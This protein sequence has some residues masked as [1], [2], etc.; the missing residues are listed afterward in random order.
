[1]VA[2]WVPLTV[3]ATLWWTVPLLLLS[4]YSPP[5]LDY[6]ENA[7]ITTST[8]SLPE[9]LLGTSDWGAYASRY[10]WVAGH[11]LG[12]TP[13][14][15]VDAAAVA[16][17]GVGG[18]ARRDNPH[19]RFLLLTLVLG[20][21]IVTFG[22][23]GPVHGWFAD[24]RQG[25]LDGALAPFR[26]LHKF[27]VV[28]RLPLVLGLAHLVGVVQVTA[29][30]VG[31]RALRA[32][33]LLAAVSAVAGVAIPVYAGQLAPTAPVQDVPR[34]WYAAADYL[35]AHTSAGTALELPAAPFGDYLWGSPHDDIL[36]ALAR[37]PWA[38]R[39]LVP[40]AQPGNVRMLD[41]VTRATE[42]SRP[43]PRLAAYL[44]S[45][46]V[47]FLVVR[48]DLQPLR[49]GAPNPVV[50]HQALDRSPGLHRVAVFGP[51]VGTGALS[52]SGGKRL[53]TDRGRS[54]VYP[55]IEV[56]RVDPVVAQDTPQVTALAAPTVPVV[57]GDPG[58]RLGTR[59]AGTPS[60]LA[61]DVPPGRRFGATYLTDG[62]TRRET[63]FTSVRDNES[64]VRAPRQPWRLA[65]V[66]HDRRLYAHELRW[67]TTLAW[68]GIAGV[69]ASSSQAYADAPPP[70][71]TAQSPAAA[72]DGRPHTQFA[73]SSPTGAQGQWWRMRLTGGL[74]PGS[75][76]ITM[77]RAGH[78]TVTRLR[79][80]TDAGAHEVPAPAPGTT[81]TF[82][83][84]SGP[85][86]SVEIR[87][88][89]VRPRGPGS[90]L[91]LAEVAVP[92]VQ[93]QRE[94]A[95]PRS[96]HSAPDQIVLVRDPQRSACAL[97]RG[98]TVCDDFFDTRSEDS[99]TLD[100]RVTLARAATYALHVQARLAFTRSAVRAVA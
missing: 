25:T 67:S 78:G 96:F 59:I 10:D 83:L 66:Q 82:G 27:D 4:R 40:L 91:A 73:T 46:G 5:F 33:V 44:A 58:S 8:T 63:V 84:P 45:N 76:T 85:T 69:S 12:T 19:A 72:V 3:A 36:Q 64:A 57:A 1:L 61:G 15:L 24:L 74:D 29:R 70:V 88:A 28:L 95:L 52:T 11:L 39:S 56:Y 20:V 60:V 48:N 80:V 98:T 71:D 35:A 100:R 75:V 94:L 49:A 30:D 2:W 68:T 31:S 51:G 89:A 7:P 92:G 50:L 97:V 42:L 9:V 32:G 16:A 21:V 65:S 34:Y 18:I 22:Y 79:L 54:A 86:R 6:I 99:N 53:L 47:G 93:P 62:L 23:T 87:A 13:L 43:Q 37:S 90:Q 17:L 41:A 38:A 55:A 81:A 14:L 77:G 26:N